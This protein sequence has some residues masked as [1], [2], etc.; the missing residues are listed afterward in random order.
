VVK[1]ASERT[2]DDA[3]NTYKLT[4]RRNI[5]A[6]YVGSNK[7]MRRRLQMFRIVENIDTMQRRLLTANQS[8]RTC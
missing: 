5:Y 3:A 4:N 7:Q 8:I 2:S 6:S 1:Q